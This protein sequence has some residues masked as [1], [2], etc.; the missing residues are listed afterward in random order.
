M[1]RTALCVT[2]GSDWLR[3]PRAA[4]TPRYDWMSGAEGG[5]AGADPPLRAP[6]GSAPGGSLGGGRP[7]CPPPPGRYAARAPAAAR[8]PPISAPRALRRQPAGTVGS[9]GPGATG[10]PA[11][12]PAAGT[13]RGLRTPEGWRAPYLPQADERALA[14][15]R[16]ARPGAAGAVSSGPEQVAGAR[17]GRFLD[18]TTLPVLC[19]ASFSVAKSP[20]SSGRFLCFCHLPCPEGENGS[21]PPPAERTQGSGL[22]C[23]SRGTRGNSCSWQVDETP[24]C[25][26]LLFLL[27]ET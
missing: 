8:S 21:L 4:P 20:A 14:H 22:C 5:A 16:N 18:R 2:R 27:L 23:S 1:Q 11:W 25:L 26:P 19:E 6:P 9:L 7:G 12:P 24:S 15:V 10:P 17:G 3:R 13:S